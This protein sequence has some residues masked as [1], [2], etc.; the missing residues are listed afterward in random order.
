MDPA[1]TRAWL[2]AATSIEDLP[3]RARFQSE[4]KTM[5]TVEVPANARGEVVAWSQSLCNADAINFVRLVRVR[6]TPKNH[7]AVEGWICEGS[8]NFLHVIDL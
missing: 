1:S 2:D 6:T 7:R 3:T 5:G 8:L 4:L